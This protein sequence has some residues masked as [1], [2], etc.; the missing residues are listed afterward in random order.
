MLHFNISYYKLSPH[1]FIS[2]KHFTKAFFCCFSTPDPTTPSENGNC[3]KT[4]PAD[5]C[6]L[7]NS[8]LSPYISPCWF[9]EWILFCCFKSPLSWPFTQAH[10]GL[11]WGWMTRDKY[12][13]LLKSAQPDSC[14]GQ[15]TSVLI[16][17]WANLFKLHTGTFGTLRR[18]S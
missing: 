14:H 18:L 17:Q 13:A 16:T 4:R 6:T 5:I 3:P 1:P 11:N 10:S 12:L 15:C 9:L 8:W 2:G 7:L